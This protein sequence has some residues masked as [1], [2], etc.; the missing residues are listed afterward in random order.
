[1]TGTSKAPASQGERRAVMIDQRG[2]A[3]IEFG[4]ISLIM[5]VFLLA[6]FNFGLWIYRQ[7]ALQN[8][9][10]AGAAYAQL[11]PTPESAVVDQIN[12]S[13]PDGIKS[14]QGISV[15]ASLVCDCGSGQTPGACPAACAGSTQRVFARLAASVP[16]TPLY[17]TYFSAFAD[18]AARYYV[19][20]Q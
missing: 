7:M 20:I 16:F 1:M 11:F 4:L 13:L 3:T 12:A 2:V 15:T 14:L 19:R 18:N 10:A 9:L 6:V 5:I 8:A 17:A